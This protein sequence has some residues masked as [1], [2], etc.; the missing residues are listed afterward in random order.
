MSKGVIRL[1]PALRRSRISPNIYGHFA[2]HLG[3][4]V[5]EGIWVDG[6]RRVPQEDG[7][8]LDI[9]AALKHLRAPVMRWPG[10]CFADDYH[11]RDGIGPKKERPTTMNLW[12]KQGEP[13]QVGTD[14]FMRFCRA[15]GC[16]P[17]VCCNVGSGSPWEAR[18]WLEYCNFG[19]DT[20][21]TR[22]RAA[23]GSPEPYGVKY[24]GVGNENW[25]CGGRY[26]GGDY[27]RDYARFATYLRAVDPSVELIACGATFD[28]YKNP[29]FNTFNHDFC[30]E[31]PYPDLIDHI[32]LHRYFKRGDGVKFS[33][34][35]F[36]ALFADVL[37]LE[38]DLE[39]TE[40]VLRYF[41]PHKHVGIAVDEW[42]MWHPS[43]TVE[44]GLEQEHTLRDALLAGSVLNLF[45]RWSHRVSMAN[46]AQTVNVLQCM[47]VTD[48]ARMFLTPTYHVFDMMRPHMG[49]RLLTRELDVP[50]YEAH[51]VGGSAKRSVAVLDASAS[52]VGR[53]ILLTVSNQS[54]DEDVETTVELREH[55]I[56]SVSGRVLNADDPRARNNFDTPGAVKPKR[57]RVDAEGGTFTHVFPAHS[58]T[59]LTIN[60]A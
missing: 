19:G 4:C 49:A 6:Q 18:D 34:G 28:D 44:N 42:G 60:L 46:I 3:R 48:G 43:A 29:L 13:N 56:A 53:K 54:I 39:L 45:N 5:Y 38:H 15:V 21:L 12:W 23:N 51:G 27:A 25:G 33:D 50:T 40:S 1:W 30:Q 2:E 22:Q 9:L 17:Y 10:G 31:M 11:W 35:D 20:T 8:R 41:Y 32:S 16:A 37:S 26:R 7:L 36:H 24:W 47:A 58:F 52:G 57:V 59:A 55:T 14:E